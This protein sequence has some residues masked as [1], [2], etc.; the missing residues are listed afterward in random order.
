LELETLDISIDR[1]SGHC[2]FETIGVCP[3]D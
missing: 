3:R 2:G 1:P